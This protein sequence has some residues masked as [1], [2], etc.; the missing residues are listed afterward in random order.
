MLFEFYCFFIKLFF[1]FEFFGIFILDIFLL[2]VGV[3]YLWEWFVF[4]YEE[5][6][7]VVG[8]VVVGEY[9]VFERDVWVERYRG[10]EVEN[11][12]EDGLEIF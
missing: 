1:W 12:V 7:G 6:C 5:G 4:G 11:F 2:V 3:E 8:V 9:V 10:L